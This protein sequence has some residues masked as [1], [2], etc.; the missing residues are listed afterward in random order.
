MNKAQQTQTPRPYPR[1][2]PPWSS[3]I[4]IVL[5]LLAPVTCFF[6]FEPEGDLSLWTI[7]IL[8]LIFAIGFGFRGNWVG[9]NDERFTHSLN[10]LIS[11][12]IFLDVLF[13]IPLLIYSVVAITLLGGL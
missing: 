5:S 12:L 2:R 1:R 7:L 11:L 3:I 8:Q 13:L 4:A 6:A 9:A 10:G